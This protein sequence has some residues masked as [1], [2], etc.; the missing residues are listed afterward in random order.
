MALSRMLPS[1]KRFLRMVES[2]LMVCSHDGWRR[3]IRS[4]SVMVGAP[5]LVE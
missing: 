4:L 3:L 5:L 2:A 1:P